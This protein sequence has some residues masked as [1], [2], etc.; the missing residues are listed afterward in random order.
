[1]GM[2]ARRRALAALLVGTM[3]GSV[4]VGCDLLPD[5]PTFAVTTTEDGVDADPGDGVCEVNDGVGDCSLRAAV[6]EANASAVVAIITVPS[7]RYEL[8]L[9]GVDDTNAAGDLDLDPA[10][11]ALII[12]NE[13]IDGY[14]IDAAAVDGGIDIL[15]GSIVAFG[16]GVG[17]ASGDGLR[18]RAGAS[19]AFTFAS[20]H[21]NGGAGVRVDADAR[22]QLWTTTVSGNGAGG[23][24]NQGATSLRF[25][26][27]R[28]GR[29]PTTAP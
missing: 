10:A 7:A 18:V 25:A 14:A 3:A 4:L 26:T 29:S 23:V 13:G 27:V 17:G 8:T 11:G 16:V 9:V 15:S 20:F 1:M 22:A 2:R 5:A 12:E 24:A 28:P 21:G 19:G 6:D